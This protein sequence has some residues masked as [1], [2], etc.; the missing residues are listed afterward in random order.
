MSVLRIATRYAKSL[1]ELASEQNKLQAVHRNMETLSEA[2]K[3]RDLYLLL[4][5]PIIKADKKN[6]VL[7]AVFGGRLDTLTMSYIRLLVN[8][9]REMYLP[10]I[11]AEFM[12]QYKRMQK[13]TS[14]RIRTAEAL[15]PEV[16]NTIKQKLV[17]SGITTAHLDVET[18]ID[19]SL[20]GGFV[21]EF[22]NQR[23]DAS[24]SKKLA[25]LKDDFS[26]NF[27]VKE[28]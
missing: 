19:R 25:N 7:D 16:L 2:A 9:N 13:I 12:D 1:I 14:L 22:D 17:A 5:S 6:A 15:T 21:L 10:E 20:I 11:T 8:K 3:N 28:F 18:T 23:Y 26:K 24:V 4:K 27:Y